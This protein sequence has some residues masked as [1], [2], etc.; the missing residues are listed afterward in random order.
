[1]RKTLRFL[2]VIMFFLIVHSNYTPAFAEKSALEYF[3]N[4]E[5]R[6]DYDDVTGKCEITLAQDSPI[7]EQNSDNGFKCYF[8]AWPVIG[9]SEYDGLQFFINLEYRANAPASIDS[10]VIKTNEYRAFFSVVSSEVISTTSG[11]KNT[12]SIN[13]NSEN[14]KIIASMCDDQQEITI[15]LAS[16]S[17]NY[18]FSVTGDEQSILA[19]L[20]NAFLNSGMSIREKKDDSTKMS[21]LQ[22]IPVGIYEKAERLE[23]KG[24]YQEAA[25]TFL[26]VESYLDSKERASSCQKQHAYEYAQNL[27]EIG[28]YDEAK[29][30]FE[31]LG[32][33]KDSKEKSKL[34]T[35]KKQEEEKDGL[36]AKASE[37]Y[38]LGEYENA[39][40]IF[41]DLGSLKDSME[42]VGKCSEMIYLQAIL[43]EESGQ[44]EEA[45]DKLSTIDDY[46]DS[47]S[48]INACKIGLALEII[49]DRGLG[50]G[51]AT[52]ID[53]LEGIE[54][55]DIDLEELSSAKYSLANA[56]VV[57]GDYTAAIK[58]YR[59]IIDY[60]DSEHLLTCT[61]RLRK[62]RAYKQICYYNGRLFALMGNGK[63]NVFGSDQMVG[64]IEKSVSSW[65]GVVQIDLYNIYRPIGLKSDGTVY[66]SDD[67][68]K[69]ISK[70]KSIVQVEADANYILGLQSSG[71]VVALNAFPL[72]R[73]TPRGA[74]DWGQYKTSGWRDIKDIA[75]GDSFSL[76]LNN[77]SKVIIAGRL[78]P[79]DSQVNNW[80][81]IKEVLATDFFGAALDEDG[82]VFIYNKIDKILS[83]VVSFWAGDQTIL[84]KCSNGTYSMYFDGRD[85]DDSV[86]SNIVPP[87]DDL[88]YFF[89]DEDVIIGV[90]NEGDSL[91]VYPNSLDLRMSQYEKIDAPAISFTNGSTTFFTNGIWVYINTLG[92]IVG[93]KDFEPIKTGSK[94]AMVKALQIMLVQHG[95]SCEQNG[96]F[97]KKTQ[98]SAAEL[99]IKLNM[100]ST[101]NIEESLLLALMNM[102]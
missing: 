25:L 8:S 28:H 27:F 24:Q 56:L 99:M 30:Q 35:E 3:N 41:L 52:A 83:D 98:E 44:F 47:L 88:A 36:Y 43:F 38:G 75:T 64:E 96:I 49:N 5:Y 1:M 78:Y 6:V 39:R 66:Y 71:R 86:I 101:K 73:S 11:K 80:T 72:H 31:R 29:G 90:A 58:E 26:E 4:Q 14:M 93:I 102:I 85:N 21:S 100:T 91:L 45:I 20:Y 68:S 60:R 97:D 37:L 69:L 10:I 51:L 54:S 46:K 62:S 79:S 74:S 48:H 23:A 22:I 77:K 87:P 15:R 61:E 70:W 84:A 50:G 55:S 92:E 34:C 33:Y 16:A 95:Y 53:L 18:D 12:I 89:I 2:S 42:L 40:S 7:M 19:R 94:G 63:V 82:N 32:D 59:E 65:E 17:D 76:G 81:N 13:L 57:N 9:Y 67:S